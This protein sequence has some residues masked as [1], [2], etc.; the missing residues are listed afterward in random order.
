MYLNI[1]SILYEKVTL[2]TVE[3]CTETL[4]MLQRRPDITRHVREML[5]RPRSKRYLR[6]TIAASGL[7]SAAV[8]ETAGTM[9]LDALRKFVWDGDEKPLH[10]DMWFALRIG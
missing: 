3:Q 5:V 7:V 1:S 6:D 8:R 9:R 2:N 4:A 10:E